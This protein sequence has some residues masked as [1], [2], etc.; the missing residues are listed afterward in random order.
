MSALAL[1]PLVATPIGPPPPA[2]DVPNPVPQPPPPPPPEGDP[3]PV[4]PPVTDPGFPPPVVEPPPMQTAGATATA[5]AV[6]ETADATA[7]VPFGKLHARRLR[8]IYRSAGWPCCDAIEVELLAG[9]FLERVRTSHGHE[10]LRVT[11]AGIARIATTLTINRAALTPH[12]ALVERVAREM[13]RGGRIAWRG[14]GLRARLPALEEGG[15]PRWCMARPDVFSIRNTSVEAYAHPIVHEVKVSRADLLG[16]LRKPDKRA[17]YLDLGGEC[18]YVLGNDARGRCIA[19]PEEVPAEC[20]VLVLEGERLVVA[21]A[22]VHRPIERMPFAVW[23]A[24]A[25]AQPISGFDE[26]VQDM[27]I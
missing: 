5:T 17:A 19:T 4:V 3:P 24:L 18:W 11:D 26:D 15:K 21:R 16:D 2:P 23:L 13:T 7:T 10:T 9:G 6:A 1:D 12:E 25:K 20:G 27:L 14:L 22:A 8:E